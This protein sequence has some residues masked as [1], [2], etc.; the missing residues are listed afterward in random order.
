MDSSSRNNRAPQPHLAVKQRRSN[1][2]EPS[3]TES[4]WQE[5]PWHDTNKNNDQM[6]GVLVPEQPK[7]PAALARNTS[8][9]SH[10]QT[11]PLRPEYNLYSPVIASK[12]SPIPRR[13]SKSPYKQRTDDSAISPD[14]GSHLRKN[15]SPFG[16]SEQRRHISP[17]EATREEAG[18]EKN[19]LKGFNRKRSQNVPNRFLDS[20]KN[21]AG[22]QLSTF[23]V[24]VRHNYNHRSRSAPKLKDREKEEQ[25]IS[26]SKERAPSPLAGSMIRKQKESGYGV[27]PSVSEI[28]EIIANAKLS[29][30]PI[31]DDSTME[32]TDS[33]AQG[34]IFFSREV[35]TLQ[36]SGAPRSNGFESNFAPKPKVV[37]ERKNVAQQSS[38]GINNFDQTTQ[39]V[40][41]SSGTSLS[42]T[43]TSTISA[44][45][46]QSSKFS[47]SSSKMSDGSQSM[48]FRK[49][50]E[51]RQRN[52]KDVCFSCVRKGA[53]RKSTSP[54]TRRIDEASF[55][56]KAFVVESI[57]QFWA[58]E[59]RPSSLSGFICHKSQAQYLRQLISQKNCPHILFKGPSG[60]GKKALCMALLHEIYGNSAWEISHDLRYFHIQEP[61]EMQVV[62][63]LTSSPHH[64]ELNLK[65]SSKNARYE[66]MALVKDIAG[67]RACTLDSDSTLK[68]DFKVIVLHEVD[69]L[70]DNVQHL[71][72]W[73]M[74]CY[75][76]ACRIML[77]CEDDTNILESVKSRCKFVAVDAPVTHEIMEVLV[78]TARKENF[79][80]P[81]SFA[82]KI[83]TKSKQNLRKAIMA[84]EACKAHNYPFIEDQPIPLGWE[85]IL[86]ELAAEILGD[87][88]PKR[89]FFARGKFQKLLVDFVHPKLILQKLVEEF[90]KGVEASL[91]RELYY[92]HAYYVSV[93]P[94]SS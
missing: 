4:E 40:A 38:R 61:Q 91:K 75:M 18:V 19:E 28:N 48:S 8:P 23:R 45:S 92:W 64:V 65:S 90:L 6:D 82:A 1:G 73:I 85:E 30:G 93:I 62:V 42:R 20:E 36:K 49:F 67:N 39:V 41:V 89:L 26:T 43:N 60:S 11:Q 29:R 51:N 78:Q 52:Q 57:R 16:V 77:C 59:H 68:A 25:I 35:Q 81:L 94:L 63:P 87:P 5:S 70:A 86:V 27:A 66:L 24:S 15:S 80:L 83:A 54:E 10:S 76:D 50:T 71:I 34:D 69:K 44:I 14:L 58:D 22:L 32:S 37:S 74:D 88:S 7:T 17:Y 84:L 47:S 9:L 46:K 12:A 79:D 31:P 21:E 3:D 13:F 53:C 72:K 55:I 2:Y 33:I 56:E